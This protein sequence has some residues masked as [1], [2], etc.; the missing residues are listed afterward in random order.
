M[1]LSSNIINESEASKLQE[2]SH[3]PHFYGLL[4]IHKM[5]DRF[6]PLQPICSGFNSCTSKLSELKKLKLT[7]P[8]SSSIQKLSWSQWMSPLFN[9]NNPNIDHQE[10]IDACETALNTRTSLHQSYVI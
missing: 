1:T 2:G 7:L 4:K 10:G 3:T 9:P 5:F 8:L 6:P